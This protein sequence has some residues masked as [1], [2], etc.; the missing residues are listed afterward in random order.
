MFSKIYVNL[1]LSK[2]PDVIL[3]FFCLQWCSKTTFMLWPSPD[4][5]FL[6]SKGR[7]TSGNLLLCSKEDNMDWSY[8]LL[9]ARNGA[10]TLKWPSHCIYLM[11]STITLNFFCKRFLLYRFGGGV[12]CIWPEPEEVNVSFL[13]E[14]NVTDWLRDLSLL[15]LL[16]LSIFLP[17]FM[18]EWSHLRYYWSSLYVCIYI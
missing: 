6:L 4:R 18:L 12:R 2:Y 3:C 10:L 14:S 8:P 1:S 7:T 17:P 9:Q 15:C 16:M 11:F 5:K 13:Y